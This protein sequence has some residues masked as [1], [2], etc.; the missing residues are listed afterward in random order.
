MTGVLLAG[1]GEVGVRAAR[2]LVETPGVQTVM[3]AAR[4]SRRVEEVCSSLGPMARR[5][6]WTPGDPVPSSTNVIASALPAEWHV[7]VAEAAIAAGVAAVL[8][9]D[10]S[11]SLGALAAL[12][13]KAAAAGVTIAAGCGL[14]PGLACVLARHAGSLFDAV[15]EVRI[16]RSGI[17][18]EASERAVR[19]ERRPLPTVLRGGR[20]RSGSRLGELVWFPEPINARDCQL[21]TGGGPLLAEAFGSLDRL[22]WSLAEGGRKRV[23]LRRVD[24]DDGWGAIRVEVF[25]RRDGEASSVVYGLVDRIALAAGATLAVAA[26]ELGGFG[27]ERVVRPGVHSLAALV[28]PV[29]FL[30]ELATRGVRAAAFVG[31]PAI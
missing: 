30:A 20:W 17:A 31:A 15:D 12:S 28:D 22:T 8:A 4:P 14:A 24:P 10:D 19:D 25:G 21:V 6:D 2:Q 27:V 29:Q 9:A 18:G 11:E 26:A 3:I 16:A 23:G 1:L 7:R 13:A 5:V